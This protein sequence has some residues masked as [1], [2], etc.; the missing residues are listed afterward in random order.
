MSTA[1][2]IVETDTV[3]VIDNDN[4]VK[5]YRYG[6]DRTDDAS[7]MN[8]VEIK[9]PS[10]RR[11]IPA[12]NIGNKVE[13]IKQ[14]WHGM[15]VNY[16]DNELTVRL[17]DVTHPENPDEL[18]T[19]SIEEIEERDQPLIQNGA[20]FLWHIGYRYGPTYPRERFS[21]IRFRRLPKWTDVE[22]ERANKLAKDYEDFFLADPIHTTSS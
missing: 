3:D 6:S 8:N 11:T 12:V 14:E 9:P 10:P 18:V 21:K 1:L 22:I 20:I 5:S 16:A 2:R 19:L 13:N 15:V 4:V 17:E 7:I